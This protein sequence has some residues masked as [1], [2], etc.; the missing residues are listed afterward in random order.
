MN[1]TDGSLVWRTHV[2]VNQI[3]LY[4]NFTSAE[5]N[6]PPAASPVYI[7]T[8]NQ[9][10]YWSFAVS[11]FG[12]DDL[13]GNDQYIGELG[14]LD[15]SIGE[16]IWTK[17]FINNGSITRGLTGTPLLGLASLK[18]TIFLTTNKHLWTFN[19]STSNVTDIK[20]FDHYILPPVKTESK[21]FIAA[22]LFL[23]AYE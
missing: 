15:L 13:S 17:Q 19:K 3:M 4:H 2:D 7:D 18:N 23:F 8:E 6:S 1:I 22:D 11:Q 12:V 16:I 21:V 5:F 10:V 14:S 20:I 9:I